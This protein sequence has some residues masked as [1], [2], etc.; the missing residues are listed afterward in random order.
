[1][2]GAS[3]SRRPFAIEIILILIV[4]LILTI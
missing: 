1:M 2:A 4:M 3:L